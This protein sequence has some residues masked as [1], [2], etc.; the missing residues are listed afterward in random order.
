MI[1]DTFR[2]SMTVLALCR[3]K[4]TSLNEIYGADLAIGKFPD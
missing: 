1:F 4:V 3:L 2:F